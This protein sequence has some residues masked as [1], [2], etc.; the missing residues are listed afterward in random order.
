MWMTENMA[1]TTTHPPVHPVATTHPPVHPVPTTVDH[2]STPP[3]TQLSISDPISNPQPRRRTRSACV[4][5]QYHPGITSV[6]PDYHTHVTK[7]S[8]QYHQGITPVSP[9]H[10]EVSPGYLTSTTVYHTS[11]TGYHRQ[12]K[13]KVNPSELVRFCGKRVSDAQQT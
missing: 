10:K 8:E 9:G 2:F 3:H 4:K 11:V 5:Y 6:S 12:I 13:R 7:V 1:N